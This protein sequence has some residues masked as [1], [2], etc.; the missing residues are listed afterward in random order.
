MY[1]SKNYI[2]SNFTLTRTEE[3]V[4]GMKTDRI[5]ILNQLYF[6]TTSMSATKNLIG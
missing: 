6:D 2:L 3:D 1:K 4:S 5:T